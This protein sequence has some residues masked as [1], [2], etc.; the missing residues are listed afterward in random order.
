MLDTSLEIPSHLVEPTVPP[1]RQTSGEEI[2]PSATQM[3]LV[4]RASDSSMRGINIWRAVRS[5]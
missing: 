1:A 5:L 3:H 4:S 2:K